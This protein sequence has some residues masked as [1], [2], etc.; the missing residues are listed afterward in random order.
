[1]GI[2]YVNASKLIAMAPGFDRKAELLTLGRQAMHIRPRF[3]AALD[4]QL[5][6][7]GYPH[8]YADLRQQDGYCETFL[9]GL[10]FANV[11]SMDVSDYEGADI[12][13][14]LNDKAPAELHGAFDVIFDGGTT[15]HV[16]DVAASMQCIGDMLAEG[17]VLISSVPGDGFFGHGFYQFGPELVY[18]YWKNGCGYEVLACSLLPVRPRFAEMEIPDPTASGE[19]P[20]FRQDGSRR[21]QYL[22]Y[23]VRKMSPTHVYKR[24]F[25]VDYLKEWSAHDAEQGREGS[26]F[27]AQ[28][29]ALAPED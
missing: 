11:R 9:R 19:R 13:H 15:E 7:A 3:R 17:G 2:D 18:D 20:E 29:A 5:A 26:Q 12:I 8:S 4:G 6:K 28:R 23:A 25:Q 24:T 21:D 10:G 27:A 1:M 22:F 14:D 16:F